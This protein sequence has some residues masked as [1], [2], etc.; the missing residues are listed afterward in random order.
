MPNPTSA[1]PPLPRNWPRFLQ[2][3]ILH[4]MS[5]AH[6]VL[7]TTRS[8]AANGA[9]ERLRLA[10]RAEEFEGFYAACSAYGKQTQPN[11]NP[12]RRWNL[13]GPAAA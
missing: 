9:N 11:C 5:L 1:L 3:T 6:Y 4:V 7:V 12:L 13:R 8:W 10:A 2:N